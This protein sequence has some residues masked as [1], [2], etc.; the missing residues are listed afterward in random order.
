M[1][2]ENRLE[3]IQEQIESLN[4]N[5][6]IQKESLDTQVAEFTQ[7][8]SSDE[9]RSIQIDEEVQI[10]ALN[11]FQEVLENSVIPTEFW[12]EIKLWIEET[13]IDQ[14][15]LDSHDRIGAWW[16]AKEV[17]SMG[18]TINFTKSEKLPSEWFPEGENWNVAQAEAR[19][20]LVRAWEMLLQ[21]EALSKK[22][23]M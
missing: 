1:D 6:D 21:N 12:D 7:T 10:A 19:F 14:L 8:N 15:Y 22:E 17:S 16:A 18:F 9:N 11:N 3:A 23:S 2:L 20:R 4:E 13:H 5:L